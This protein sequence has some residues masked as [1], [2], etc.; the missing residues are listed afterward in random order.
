M[1]SKRREIG[2]FGIILVFALVWGIPSIALSKRAHNVGALFALTGPPSVIGEPQRKTAEMIQ[3]WVNAAGGFSG[4]PLQVIVYDTKGDKEIAAL[5]LGKLI[6]KEG[7]V[8]VIG[9]S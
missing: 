2:L 8:A 9:T 1:G 7:V 6:E 4:N 3:G 5:A